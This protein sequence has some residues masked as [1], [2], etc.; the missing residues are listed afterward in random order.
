M[1]VVSEVKNTKVVL[2]LEKGSQTI[3]N[4]A[5]TASDESLYGLGEAVSALESQGV[6]GVTKV[7]ETTLV[8]D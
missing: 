3:P 7:V 2:K 5:K 4:C 8:N 6:V 1:A